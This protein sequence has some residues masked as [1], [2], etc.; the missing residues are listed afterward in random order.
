MEITIHEEK[1]SHFTFHGGKRADHESRKYRLTPSLQFITADIKKINKEQMIIYVF[2]VS[3]SIL[4]NYVELG[5][6]Y[7]IFQS[8][9]FIMSYIRK[10]WEYMSYPGIWINYKCAIY[11]YNMQLEY[12]Q[13]K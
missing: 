11:M 8:S 3:M 6:L 7:W 5:K 4:N 9:Q 13:V 2:I 10:N 1:N 12:S